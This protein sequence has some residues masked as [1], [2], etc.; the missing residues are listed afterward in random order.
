MEHVHSADDGRSPGRFRW[1]TS[2]LSLALAIAGCEDD[3]ELEL[4][5]DLRTD[6]VAGIEFVGVR[7]TIDDERTEEA[8]TGNVSYVDGRRLFDLTDLQPASRR[9][10]R[11]DLL[12]GVGDVFASREVLISHDDDLAV[13]V[14]MSRDCSAVVCGSDE[15]CLGGRCVDPGCTDGSEEVCEDPDCNADSDCP[16]MAACSARACREG[17]CLYD[18][19]ECEA[20]LY[21]AP[22]TGC[23]PVPTTGDMGPRDAGTDLGPPDLGAPDD[24]LYISPTG[25]DG[26]T[27][28]RTEPLRTFSVALSRLTAGDTLIA[29]PGEYGSATGTDLIEVHCQ[30]GGTT[31]AGGPC[32]EGTA[33]NPIVI[34][35]SEERAARL[36]AAAG[37]T[38]AMIELRSCDHY[39]IEGFT[40]QGRDD[41]DISWDAISVGQSNDLTLRRN[42]IV[43]SNRAVNGHLISVVNSNDVLVEENE[44]YDF[45]RTGI[46]FHQ[47]RRPIARRNY[48]NSRGYDD[49]AGGNVSLYPEGGDTAIGCSHSTDCLFE[50]N[51]VEGDTEDAFD[52]GTSVANSDGL[53][54]EGD[55][56]RLLGNLVR[57]TVRGLYVS[58]G[59]Q[60]MA[61]CMSMDERI[62]DGVTVSD[63]VVFDTR[64]HGVFVR[65]AVDVTLRNLTI[66]DATVR[67]DENTG[68][69][70][71]EPTAFLTNVA[72][73]Y[74]PGG[75]ST[76]VTV[77]DQE[78][79]SI[80]SSNSFGSGTGF[81][82]TGDASGFVGN[83]EVDPQLG[84]C[85]HR[86][87]STSP[88]S[89]AGEGGGDIG[90]TVVFRTEDGTLTATPLWATDGSFPC[91]AV[92]SGLNDGAADCSTAHTRLNVGAGCAVQ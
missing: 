17:I 28:S 62:I 29:L 58:S 60:G 9:S 37:D 10:I 50:N 36:V 8:L 57:G 85:I 65:G 54:R 13:T 5:I 76:G 15:S 27:G 52:I 21:C 38:S 73:S 1:L 34:R 31:C 84:A 51:L 86:I 18:A 63:H 87:P 48:V 49:I 71:M 43:G 53:G 69:A 82:T 20:G 44:L 83:T 67:V 89:G 40:L 79:W 91:G 88:L 92:V 19:V 41:A 66:L 12:D 32:A 61:G 16:A 6:W 78:S 42:L 59:C 24:A 64:E 33:A 68:N 75:G 81:D 45:H 46:Q 7:A 26:A 2:L 35:A 77:H 25:D 39:W 72:V 55:G 3:S 4:S 47:S 90:A 23:V 70:P 80:R 30:A 56:A 11:I 74:P 14:V 22:E